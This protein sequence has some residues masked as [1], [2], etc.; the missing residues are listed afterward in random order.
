MSVPYYPGSLYT[1]TLGLALTGMDEVLAENMV[2]IDTAFGGGSSVN[3]NGS[4]VLSPNFNGTTPSAP[5]GKSNITFQV[6]AN[7]NISAYYT[8]G[9]AGGVTSITGDSVVY[10]N[11][12]STGAVTLSLISQ[13]PNV[14][15]AGPSSGPSA[16]PTFRALVAADI[17]TL[18]YMTNPMTTL[19]DVIYGG[20]SG[21]ATRLAGNTTT[22]REF[23]ISTGAASAATAPVW[24][25]LVS[26]DI[27]NNAA[28]TSGTAANLSGTPA[29]PNG[30]TATTQ[31]TGDTSTDLA[32]DAF[33]AAA[34]AAYTPPAT[35]WNSIAAPTGSLTLAVP[36]GDNTTFNSAELNTVPFTFSWVNTQAGT[37]ASTNPS[38]TLTLGSFGFAG[39]VS[40]EVT[41][42]IGATLA[43][44]A[45]GAATLS[46][47]PSG[48]GGTSVLSTPA[49]CNLATGQSASLTVPMV[50]VGGSATTGIGIVSAGYTGYF[51][52]GASNGHW[53]IYGGTNG[54]LL[55][56]TASPQE[57]GIQTRES[58][59]HLS[60]SGYQTTQTNYPSV[61]FNNAQASGGTFTGTSGTQICAAVAPGAAGLVTFNPTSGYAS[62]EAFQINPTIN[63]TATGP[64]IS[65]AVIT[66][67]TVAAV[68]IPSTTGFVTGA[69]V[70]I[71]NITTT[72]F[73]GLNGTWVVAAGST[74]TVL[75]LTTTGLSAKAQ[76][77]C[78]G[79]VSLGAWNPSFGGY[80]ALTINA[81]ETA[82]ITGV[83]NLL[84]D[85]Y[86]G[87][88]GTTSVYRVNNKGV[89][90]VYNGI[91]TVGNGVPSELATVD[92]T[93]QTSAITATTLYA[94]TA[95]GMYRVSWSAA[96][97]T[98]D[99]TSS[100]LGG[101]NGF[102]VLYTSPTD[103]A[104][105][106]TVA[107]N[108]T[109]SAA[110]TTGT[111]V[112]G[113]IVVYAKTGTNIQYTYGYTAG[114]GNMAYE[115]HVRLEAM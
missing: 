101:T 64:A 103:S 53:F 61:C 24:G 1:P 100:V 63:N 42:T 13:S 83:N 36:N 93:A 20:V 79:N 98:A 18:A 44:T 95:S 12:A 33:V 87:S 92:L 94:T 50:T 28:N 88:S 58:G 3:V 86:A 37:S 56:R 2:I 55:D 17:P 114:T 32:T 73:T 31:T 82:V 40:T 104:V 77:S 19:G 76:A 69:N 57:Y 38:P 51:C 35:K 30:T 9:S 72:G 96:I 81:V 11:A 65:S 54:L 52:S 91:A 39:S 27:P 60:I 70:T 71:A 22:T 67:A 47:T 59:S 16:A 105:K 26:G 5:S 85:F 8:A 23:L 99:T 108:S 45:T 15:F 74:S 97:T 14:V 7:G 66:S 90:T 46:I 25:A 48:G 107:G 68:T 115:L 89:S 21:A 78:N 109:T 80:S 110:N 113:S 10:N 49:F 43:A 62:F 102:Q 84:L 4:L 111:A 112:G 75:N 41:W 29:L 106:T 34:I 6:D